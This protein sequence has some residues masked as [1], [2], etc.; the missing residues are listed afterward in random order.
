MTVTLL[1]LVLNDRKEYTMKLK[2][3]LLVTML[4]IATSSMAF[5]SDTT[6]YYGG[7]NTYDRY[8]AN[9]TNSFSGQAKADEVLQAG[10]VI[11]ATLITRVTS[12]NS[13]SVV[14][15]VVRQDVYDSV[16]GNNV[17]I[18]AGSRLIG[19]PMGM[20]GGRINIAFQRV[21]F[22][23][24]NS[25]MLPNYEAI[26][27]LG[28]TGLKDKYSTHSWVKTR[29]VLTG[30]IFAGLAGAATNNSS[31]VNNNNN[32]NSAYTESVSDSALK[33]AMAQAISGMTSIATQN[34]SS[35]QPTGT[36]REGYQFNVMLHAD[37][38][39]K[40]YVQ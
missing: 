11:P 31:H 13:N 36:V 5:A 29:A 24:G 14:T 7:Q 39:V 8:N 4:A 16:T 15:A 17:L 10:T 18:P 23:N 30:A 20:N 28:Q 22:P 33:S 35:V 12:D 25:V 21:I 1:L 6:N 32:S 40:P 37:I 27:G 3:T 2:K 9:S 38:R 26:D 34:S 19:E